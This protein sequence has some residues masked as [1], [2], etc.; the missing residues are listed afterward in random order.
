MKQIFKY[1]LKVKKGLL[2]LLA[3]SFLTYFVIELWLNNY[4]ELFKGASKVG[5]LFSSLAISYISAFIFYF[6]VVHIKSEKDKENINEYVGFKVYSILSTSHL[7]I[8]PF[9][10]MGNKKASFKDLDTKKLRSLLDSINR[11]SKE[12]P[13][14]LNGDNATWLQWWEYLKE[15]TFKSF[16]EIF[17]R[18]NHIDTELIKILT[19]MENSIFFTQ[20][21]I[22][23]G[24]IGVFDKS[25][26]LYCEQIKMYLKHVD[27]LQNYADKNLREYQN[28][29]SDFMGHKRKDYPMV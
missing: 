16:N 10:E 6:V 27:D 13:Y 5:Q 18:Y 22:L 15:S 26:G 29:T 19:R 25:F 7:F 1:F 23:Y 24:G 4:S 14:F 28:M 8:Q 12:A 21:D 3:L 9:L 11:D 2:V 17:I 20:W